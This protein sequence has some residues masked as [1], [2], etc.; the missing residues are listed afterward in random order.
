MAQGWQKDTYNDFRNGFLINDTL[1]FYLNVWVFINGIS[2]DQ[3]IVVDDLQITK[4]QTNP[5]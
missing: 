3:G 1:A 2:I 5:P 4:V